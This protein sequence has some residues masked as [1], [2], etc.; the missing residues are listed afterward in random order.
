ML[1]GRRYITPDDVKKAAVP[2]LAHRLVLT[3]S[4]QLKNDAA[5]GIIEDILEGTPVPTEAH[6]DGIS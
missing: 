2:T 1:D 5:R 6:F 4:E 3:G